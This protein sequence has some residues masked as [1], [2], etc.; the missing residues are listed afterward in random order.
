MDLHIKKDFEMF[1][2][3]S[4]SPV[5]KGNSSMCVVCRDINNEKRTLWGLKAVRN[6]VKK[7]NFQKVKK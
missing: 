1:T 5:F 6:Q 3:Q 4:I 7:K 2:G